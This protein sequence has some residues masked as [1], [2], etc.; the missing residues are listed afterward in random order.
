M[1]QQDKRAARRVEVERRDLLR[2]E[3][4]AA[5]R[6]E[7]SVDLMARMRMYRRCGRDTMDVEDAGFAD[8]T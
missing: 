8:R 2:G 3:W 5:A 4:M 1:L 7:Q 6:A